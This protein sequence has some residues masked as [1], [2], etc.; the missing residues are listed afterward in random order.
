MQ[1]VVNFDQANVGGW[2]DYVF[3][4]HVLL[5]PGLNGFLQYFRVKILELLKVETD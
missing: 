1:E 2:D 4:A 3:I 5:A